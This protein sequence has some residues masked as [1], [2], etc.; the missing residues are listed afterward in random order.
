M[1]PV[2]RLAAFKDS[3]KYFSAKASIASKDIEKHNTIKANMM[4]HLPTYF[5]VVTFLIT[6][7][8]VSGETLER[9]NIVIIYA[10][11][12]GYGDCTANNPESKIPTPNIDR[13]AAEGMRFTDA[14]SPA[15]VCTPSRYGLLT[16]INP[17]REGIINPLLKFGKPIIKGDTPT[18]ADFLK[19]Q[20]YAT[21]MIGKWHLGFHMDMSSGRVEFD[22]SKPL[23][24]GPVDCGFDY[25]YGTHSSP[26]SP[27]YFYIRNRDAVARPTK[28][29]RG[30]SNV[31]DRR[32]S[33]PAGAT[34]PGFVHTEVMPN[35]L[36]ETVGLIHDHAEQNKDKPL[37]IY[38][39]LTAP[40]TPLVPSEKF[41]GKSEVGVYGDFIMEID[42]LVGKVNAALVEEGMDRNTILIFSSD[43]GALLIRG[44]KERHGHSVNGVLRGG[45]ALPYEGGHRVPFLLKWPAVVPAGT[46]TDATVNHTDIFATLIDILGV[47]D[48][49]GYL[50]S[51]I[52][53][54]SFLHVL[55][56]PD[57]TFER[58]A[59]FNTNSTCRIGD[60][61]I[62]AGRKVLQGDVLE[63]SRIELYNLDEDLSEVTD[64]S[65]DN[66][67]CLEQLLQTYEQFRLNWTIRPEAIM[68]QAGKNQGKEMISKI[69]TR[70]DVERQ[71][72]K[73]EVLG[74]ED[75]RTIAELQK[76]ID[77]V[78][79]EPQK[80]ARD[81]A[82]QKALEEGKK[83]VAL[84]AAIDAAFEFTEQQKSRLQSLREEL[85]ELMRASR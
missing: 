11:D 23:T 37:F 15:T 68:H 32:L 42:D 65:K 79:T 8:L 2:A 66:P 14:H 84:R 29:I 64:L 3:L 44:D 77:D 19:T 57:A 58:P 52:E 18:I 27:P 48:E 20:G 24:G 55:K 59:M 49:N 34:A 36:K 38:F 63:I 54:H 76:K 30:P 67:E 28:V 35:L 39:A 26:S 1:R 41:V 7:Q 73:A 60:W 9:P 71:G 31:E 47:R 51:A 50:S 85:S 4:K 56:D 46:V 72:P 13:L 6:P 33:W 5:I 43:N 83:G 53:S 70:E 81:A 74:V 16:G 21:K 40:H 45:K 61:K 80:Q 75:R 25:Y 78:F 69:D 62:V 12:M 82:R 17:A 22:F 10:D